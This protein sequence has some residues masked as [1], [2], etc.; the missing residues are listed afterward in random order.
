MERIYKI[1]TVF[2]IFIGCIE[3]SWSLSFRLFSYPPTGED[4][5]RNCG[6][7]EIELTERNAYDVLQKVAKKT[8]EIPSV[9]KFIHPSRCKN[10]YGQMNYQ[11]ITSIDKDKNSILINLKPDSRGNI[12]LYIVP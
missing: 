2:S 7:I 9:M 5:P 3:P 11:D 1:L 10:K 6:E 8:C 12:N 4:E